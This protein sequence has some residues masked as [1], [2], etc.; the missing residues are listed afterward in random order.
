MIIFF[1]NYIEIKAILFIGIF[2]ETAIIIIVII[3]L[4]YTNEAYSDSRNLFSNRGIRD[5]RYVQ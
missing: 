3:Y 5:C 1:I 4:F 2:S